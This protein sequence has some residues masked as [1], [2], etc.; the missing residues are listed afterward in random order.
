MVRK[1]NVKFKVMEPEMA[2]AGL[3]GDAR[4]FIEDEGKWEPCLAGVIKQVGSPAYLLAMN[5]ETKHALYTLI[6]RDDRL[7]VANLGARVFDD[8]D[9]LMYLLK[10]PLK[11]GTVAEAYKQ[12]EESGVLR[13]A[14]IVAG[15]NKF[16]WT[17][18][19]L[20]DVIENIKEG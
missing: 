14:L 1:E 17:E 5:M 9:L 20:K 8:S 18:E 6:I 11:D 2:F 3:T 19:D 12:G 13:L 7:M 16:E 15:E 4:Q 10:Y